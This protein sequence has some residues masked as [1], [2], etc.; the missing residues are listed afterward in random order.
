ML[1]GGIQ[2]LLQGV[3]KTL[4]IEHF[5]KKI[6]FCLYVLSLGSALLL[7]FYYKFDLTGV[8]CGWLTGII[9]LLVYEVRFL[10]KME[11]EEAFDRV[12]QK[13]RV[14]EENIR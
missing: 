8:W 7:G 6:V 2:T 12:R 3:M 14:M 11:W 1:I 9:V 10:W 13:Y 4:Q 5:G